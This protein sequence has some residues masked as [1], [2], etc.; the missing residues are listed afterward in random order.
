MDILWLIIGLLVG[1]FIGLKSPVVSFCNSGTVSMGQTRLATRGRSRSVVTVGTARFEDAQT[2]EIV[3][4]VVYV[5]GERQSAPG[6]PLV[7]T[8]RADVVD[9]PLTLTTGDVTIAGDVKGSVTTTSGDIDIK[10][11][12]TGNVSVISGDVDI[13]G[14][15]G[16]SVRTVSGDIDHH[17]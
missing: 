17:S 6:A 8:V 12:V 3:N 11:N 2:V 9:G 10:G 15:V 4:G 16:G 14:S 13:G 7:V 1:F 5:N